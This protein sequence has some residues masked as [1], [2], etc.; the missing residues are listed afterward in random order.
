MWDWYKERVQIQ[1]RYW[2]SYRRVGLVLGDGYTYTR[3]AGTITGVRVKEEG[4]RHRRCTGTVESV[5][6]MSRGKG[7]DTEEVQ[8]VL[9]Q[10]KPRG[11]GARKG[12]RYTEGARTITECE[13][14]VQRDNTGTNEE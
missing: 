5:R 11:I 7:T 9:V 13:E 12:N 6:G 2:Y 1:K 4:Y 10:L 3:G 14:T 8:E